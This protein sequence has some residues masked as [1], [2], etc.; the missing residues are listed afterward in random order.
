MRNPKIDKEMFAR[1]PNA[2]AYEASK[3][4]PTPP[5]DKKSNPP[6]SKTSNTD[7][8]DIDRRYAEFLKGKN[9]AHAAL[10]ASKEQG[11]DESEFEE[12][13]VPS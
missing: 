13:K 8:S 3:S 10:L 12:S 7:A 1:T 9:A 11:E 5:T 6:A 2:C 4:F